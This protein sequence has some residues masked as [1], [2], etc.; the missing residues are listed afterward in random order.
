MADSKRVTVIDVDGLEISLE[1]NSRFAIFHIMQIDKLT[2]GLV[3]KMKVWLDD[4]KEFFDVVGLDSVYAAAND[5]KIIRLLKLL[6]FEYLGTDSN[7]EVYKY[8]GN[9]S[10][11]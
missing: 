10:S 7:L 6:N 5:K 2:K 1:Y 4:W 8:G 9:T 11:N 3:E